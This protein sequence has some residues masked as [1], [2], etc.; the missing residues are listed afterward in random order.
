[1]QFWVHMFTHIALHICCCLKCLY[2]LLEYSHMR[3]G[4]IWMPI[5][6]LKKNSSCLSFKDFHSKIWEFAPAFLLFCIIYCF[7]HWKSSSA[8]WCCHGNKKKYLLRKNEDNKEAVQTFK[9]DCE[10]FQNIG[11]KTG[12]KI[13]CP[14]PMCQRSSQIQL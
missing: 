7:I 13:I 2:L 12:Q 8:E 1:M 14:G 4:W 6:F 9:S 11:S 5:N 3:Q 10:D